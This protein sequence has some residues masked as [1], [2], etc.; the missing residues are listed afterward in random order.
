M[1]DLTT[2][3]NRLAEAEEA[4]HQLMLGA[5][6]VSVAMGNYGSTTYA[7]ANAEKLEQDLEKLKSQI[8][9]LSGTAR[10]GVIKVVFDE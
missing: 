6:E 4:Q 3:Q 9:R 7:Q 8:A 5:K 1:T 10:R 2:L